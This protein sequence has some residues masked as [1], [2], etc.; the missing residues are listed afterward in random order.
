DLAVALMCALCFFVSFRN[1]EAIRPSNWVDQ[2]L[3]FPIGALAFFD[4][5]YIVFPDDDLRQL[6]FSIVICI[7]F[8]VLLFFLVQRN[9]LTFDKSSDY[10]LFFGSLFGVFLSIGFFTLA[11][12]EHSGVGESSA[13]F[14]GTA[15]L[16]GSAAA[17]QLLVV[18][19]RP[20]DL[21]LAS[22]LRCLL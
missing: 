13:L 17:V 5:A 2:L 16:L 21:R 11:G 12:P 8:F 9:P 4:Y 22:W 7:S 3:V 14:L 20:V 15:S 1:L 18:T 19:F 10:M 6:F